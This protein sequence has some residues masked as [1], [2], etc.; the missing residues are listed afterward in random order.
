MFLITKPLLRVLGFPGD[1][2]ESPL[3]QCPA[4]VSGC[5]GDRLERVGSEVSG[6]DS[7]TLTRVEDLDPH[8]LLWE[9]R[10]LP[11]LL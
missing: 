6:I 8:T 10:R 2:K 1:G 9:G 4:I 11:L 5:L 3:P 7:H